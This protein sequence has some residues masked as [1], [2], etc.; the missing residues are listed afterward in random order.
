MS[1]RSSINLRRI[2][3]SCAACLL[4]GFAVTAVSVRDLEANVERAIGICVDA[5]LL[6]PLVVQYGGGGGASAAENAT[7]ELAVTGYSVF[8]LPIVR[9]RLQLDD[10]GMLASCSVRY[11]L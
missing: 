1:S 8:R 10:A 5:P 2:A 7:G 6:R 11:L 4:A 9:V 3:W